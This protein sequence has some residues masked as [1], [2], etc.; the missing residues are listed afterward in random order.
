[1][2]FIANGTLYP[3]AGT[4][5]ERLERGCIAIENGKIR[6][7]GQDFTYESICEEDQRTKEERKTDIYIDA[8]V[9]SRHTAIW[10]SQRRKRG[11]KG[12]TVMR[13]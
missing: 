12:M 9:S 3:M 6:R 10:E 8:A 13:R 11:W 2:L 1:M 7:V 5:P 4:M